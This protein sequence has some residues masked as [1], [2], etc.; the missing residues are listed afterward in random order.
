MTGGYN[1]K[2]L[3]VDLTNRKITEEAISDEMCRK[4]IGGSGFGIKI[5]M[6]EVPADCDP[7]GPDNKVIFAIGPFTNTG[8]IEAGKHEVSC[9]SPQTGILAE[10][11]CGGTWGAM[12]K[13]TGYDAIILEGC[14]DKPCYLWVTDTGVEIRD[15]AHLWG[16]DTIECDAAVV[17]ET[18]EKAVVSTVGPAAEKGVLYC[19]VFCDGSESRSAGRA[20]CGTVMASKNVKAIAVYG[21]K[22]PEVHDREKLMASVREV[23]KTVIEKAAGLSKFGTG[24]GMI[25]GEK[26]GNIPIKNWS[27]GNFAG[28]EK[29]SGQVE[30]EKYLI[31]QYRC[32]SCIIGCGRTSQVKEGKYASI[33]GAG[34]EY[35]TLGLLGSN[36]MI[37]DMEAI[38][39]AN[40]L[41]NRY[42]IDTMT[43]G[44][45]IGFA[46]ECYEKG[47]VTKEDL[48]VDLKWGDAEAMIEMIHQIGQKRGFGG[49]VLYAGVKRAAEII[50]QGSEEF[51]VHV[52]GLE[53]ACHDPRGFVSIGVGYATSNRGACH[54]QALSH[55]MEKEAAMPEIGY[56]APLDRF[57]QEGKGEMVAKMQHIMTMCDS[58]KLCKF[59]ISRGIYPR[60]CAEWLQYITGWDYT[61]DEFLLAGERLYNLKRLFNLRCGITA[62]D[63]NLPPRLASWKRGTGGSPDSLPDLS[64]QL[65]EYYKFRDWDPQTGAPSLKKLQELDI[66]EYYF[67]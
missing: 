17:A 8:A 47:L 57:V 24:G 33:V 41:C 26:V 2:F 23:T 31:K 9:K 53:P 22:K 50:G 3:R 4:Y 66:A 21:K 43:T 10:S 30:T 39:W 36:L 63:D 13:R 54:L 37:D 18:H 19:G 12:M 16:K 29:I 62:A 46:M 49:E 40:E 55:I 38:H 44:T 42:G 58:L 6:D 32:A 34:P 67:G 7:L 65:P 25:G 51:A 64:I 60:V 56:D 14:A 28:A 20:G 5:L 61:V 52:K 59:A 35:E 48:G 15:A 1:N 27:L 11:D 45:A